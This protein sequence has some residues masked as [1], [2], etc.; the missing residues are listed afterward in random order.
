MLAVADV[1][2]LDV[3]AAARRSTPQL[4]RQTREQIAFLEWKTVSTSTLD[5]TSSRGS[6]R[7]IAVD[8]V[9]IPQSIV[10]LYFCEAAD[11]GGCLL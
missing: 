2:A 4:Y 9:H 1:T 5:R 6:I 10:D 11:A 7:K 3:V 8:L